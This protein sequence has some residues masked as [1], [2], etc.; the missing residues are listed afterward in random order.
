VNLD[1]KPRK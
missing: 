1:A